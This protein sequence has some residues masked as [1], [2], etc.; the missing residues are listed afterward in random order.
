MDLIDLDGDGLK[1][2]VTGKRFW[3]HG[4]GGDAEPNSPAVLYWFML[5]RGTD[6]SVD[7]T[8]YLIDDDSG[9]GTQVMAGNIGRG[10]YPGVVVGNK[11]GTFVFIHETRKVSQEEWEKAQPKPTAAATASAR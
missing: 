3:A 4:A 1:D 11:K 6:K 2:I 9:I 5:V 8:P 10:K 7:F